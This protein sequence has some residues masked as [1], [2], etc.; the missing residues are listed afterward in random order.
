GLASAGVPYRN[1]AAP[2]GAPAVI[3]IGER[4]LPAISGEGLPTAEFAAKQAD[5]RKELGAALA[6]AGYPTMADPAAMN[7]PLILILLCLMMLGATL[8]CGPIPAT[9]VEMYPARIRYTSMSLAFHLGNGWFGGFMPT[10]A[11]AIVAA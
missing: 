2:A 7:Q 4:T 3:R 9:V 11:F 6:Q 1:E 8:V 10:I 5:W